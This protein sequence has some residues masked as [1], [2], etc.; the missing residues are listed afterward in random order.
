MS[1]NSEK[2]QEI[3]ATVPVHEQMEAMQDQISELVAA[4]KVL[5][6]GALIDAPK[7]TDVTTRIQTAKTKPKKRAK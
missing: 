6:P 7:Y 2:R 4:V 1:I 3:L 5:N